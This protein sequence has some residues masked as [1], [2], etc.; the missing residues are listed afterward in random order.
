MAHD[1]KFSLPER[2]LGK[3][4]VEFKIS[5]N[6]GLM[7][8]LCVSKGSLVWYPKGNTY[9]YKVSWTK[10]DTFMKEQQQSESR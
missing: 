10:F 7:G 8:T 1:V 6:S 9:G 3:S 4:D 5:N 2:T